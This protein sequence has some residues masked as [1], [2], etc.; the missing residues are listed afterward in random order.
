M[1][2]YGGMRALIISDVHSNL[3]AFDAVLADA[4]ARGGYDVVW[5]L[6]DL[7]GYGAEPG[8]CIARLRGL[9][10]VAIAGNHDHAAIGRLNPDR[11]N[12]A[13]RAAAIW[14][15]AQLT[16]EERD[17][18]A[19]WPEVARIDDFTLVHGSLRD[20]VM[21]YL[22]SESAARATFA[23]LDTRFCLVG[24]SHYPL[25]WTEDDGRVSAARPEPA[26]PLLLAN[27]RR[28]IVNPGSVGQPRDGDRR[29]SYLLY[30]S[31]GGQGAGTLEYGRVEYDIGAAQGKILAA[32]L[33]ETLAWRLDDGR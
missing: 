23:L 21:E 11:F 6:G 12:G 18:L 31:A 33:P 17:Y 16:G 10:H 3:E 25:V 20:P 8:A 26:E 27:P 24:H 30:D 14:T 29:A 19:G 5:F 1:V 28:R 4:E 32:G 22:I 2:A 15:A 13:A 9:P 7:V